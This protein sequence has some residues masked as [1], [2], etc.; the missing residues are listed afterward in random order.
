MVEENSFRERQ[1]KIIKE[2]GDIRQQIELLKKFFLLYKNSRLTEITKNLFLLMVEKE[3]EI[4]RI[5]ED[6]I[7]SDI[8]RG[9]KVGQ[10]IIKRINEGTLSFQETELIE[11][12]FYLAEQLTQDIEEVNNK[13]LILSLCAGCL[14]VAFESDEKKRD[15]AT[16]AQTEKFFLLVEKQPKAFL[17]SA[18]FNLM[19]QNHA[20]PKLTEK[21][22]LLIGEI[23]EYDK[24]L[25][26]KLLELT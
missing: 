8:G 12:F 14:K 3:K 26:D 15:L 13:K 6:Q 17:F 9:R 25:R 21:I 23:K 2:A 10:F 11:E 18:L 5:R 16:P 20:K 1:L 7:P 19:M 24:D 4:E 22:E